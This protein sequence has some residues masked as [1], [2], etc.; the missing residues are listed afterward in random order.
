MDYL[1]LP[2]FITVTALLLR[3]AM[4]ISGYLGR[5]E[6]PLDRFL[7]HSVVFFTILILLIQGCGTWGYLQQR[8]V[9]VASMLIT[10]LSLLLPKSRGPRRA[11]SAD[12]RSLTVKH[13]PLLMGYWYGVLVIGEIL[14]GTR[15]RGPEDLDVLTY[16]LGFAGEWLASGY[17][18]NPVQHF[19]DFS[20]PF[21]PLNTSVLSCWSMLW[22][23]SDVVA[24]YTQL[25]FVPL[26]IVALYQLGRKVSLPFEGASLAAL[27]FMLIPL[28]LHDTGRPFCDVALAALVAASLYQL[29]RLLQAPD[30][31][32]S[33]MAGLTTG[34]MIGT[35]YSAVP[36]ALILLPL[37]WLTLRQKRSRCL[38]LTVFS[39]ALALA[40]GYTYLRNLL[41]MGNPIFP[42]NLAVKDKIL[43]PGW[44]SLET[45]R[46]EERDF[47]LA[48]LILTPK[49]LSELGLISLILIV[50]GV[51]IGALLSGF[52]R[53]S[54][55]T[56]APS[57]LT[58]YL[59]WSPILLFGIYYWLLPYRHEVRFF[60]PAITL[61]SVT[62]AYALHALT[63]PSVV[64]AGL[65]VSLAVM[66]PY[67]FAHRY[68][69]ALLALGAATLSYILR[70]RLSSLRNK[71]QLPGLLL[72]FGVIIVAV[73]LA[74]GI[75]QRY[76]IQKWQSVKGDFGEVLRW[77]S[78]AQSA[79]SRIAYAGFNAPYPLYGATYQNRVVFI[80]HVKRWP[81]FYGFHEP[82]PQLP[83]LGDY[84]SWYYNL[85]G[86][87]PDIVV[88]SGMTDELVRPE[89][90]WCERAGLRRVLVTDT[91]VVYLNPK[92]ESD[93]E[94]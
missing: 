2:V 42:A 8:P 12:L 37:V 60:L 20:P 62:M 34:L 14:Y 61:G 44:I 18:H 10:G 64:G 72:F 80:P 65:L 43:L 85:Q 68:I 17:F 78:A 25:L 52:S 19:G 16:H 32:R 55:A 38:I 56:A 53:W 81:I 74:S 41:I 29:V 1:A 83:G 35:K 59:L 58:R 28:T 90:A 93:F 40:G 46:T 49:T 39:L 94:E 27:A 54:S 82:K 71:A 21:Y 75:L 9:L 5:S 51:M 88:L 69:L 15:W 57:G 30:W 24:R 33:L 87:E 11:L 84:D 73:T 6:H 36:F 31:R 77:L 79:Q 50:P 48:G 13:I 22:L 7:E 3:A 23:S 67:H 89:R 91:Y 63:V 70:H 76:Q 4:R 26:G 45:L 86:L 66:S 92:P 47:S